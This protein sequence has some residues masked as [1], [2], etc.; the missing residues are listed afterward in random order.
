MIRERIREYKPELVVMYGTRD[1]PAWEAI[2]GQ[3]FPPS[4]ILLVEPTVLVATPHPVSRGMTN[5]YW[6]RL[7]TKLRQE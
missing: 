2:A 6:K 1:L 7:G 3:P 5:E 4:G